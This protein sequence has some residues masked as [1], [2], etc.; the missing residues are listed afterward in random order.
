MACG[1]RA[2]RTSRKRPR[3]MRWPTGV[4]RVVSWVWRICRCHRKHANSY[5][6]M[7]AKT[8][9]N[10]HCTRNA[11]CPGLTCRSHSTRLPAARLRARNCRSGPRARASCIRRIWRWNSVRRSSPRNT[12]HRWRHSWWR[13]KAS[14]RWSISPADSASI[15]APWCADS[16]MAPMWSGRRG[17]ARSRGIICANLVSAVALTWCAETAWITL[18]RCRRRR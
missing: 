1:W 8:C 7:P 5:A 11:T 12:R 3:H 13:R 16:H 6:R 4:A 15:S 9:A 10:W 18:R 14:P 2:F 17:C